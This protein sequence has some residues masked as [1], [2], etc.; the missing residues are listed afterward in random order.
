MTEQSP[1][2][3]SAAPHLIAPTGAHAIDAGR[4]GAWLAGHVP[5]AAHGVAVA[6]FQ[7]G[8]SNPTYLLSVT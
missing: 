1:D 5:D 3:T 2:V 6:Q 7:G 8:M 4:L